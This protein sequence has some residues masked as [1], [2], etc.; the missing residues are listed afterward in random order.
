MV[1]ISASVQFKREPNSDRPV[2]STLNQGAD[3][4]F[5]TIQFF[6]Q[7][8]AYSFVAGL[9][10]VGIVTV[11]LSAI[12]SPPAFAQQAELRQLE[13]FLTPPPPNT[14]APPAAAAPVQAPER[15]T[16]Q[17]TQR[18]PATTTEPA[19]NTPRQPQTPQERPSQVRNPRNPNTGST[20]ERVESSN[21]AVRTTTIPRLELGPEYG[22]GNFIVLMTYEGDDSLVLAQEYSAGAFV[23]QINGDR[24]IQLAV[25]DQIEYA[26]HL[27]DRLRNQGLSVLVAN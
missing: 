11:A 8:K 1:H 2:R 20:T 6:S 27:A 4:M 5:V 23:K 15:S 24:Y 16:P 17:P 22:E 25:F 13:E 12:S 10:A 14:P 3:E 18:P 9:S 19:R 7:L 26:R 21:V